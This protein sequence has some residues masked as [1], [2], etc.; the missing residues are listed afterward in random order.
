MVDPVAARGVRG[1][2][3][4]GIDEAGGSVKEERVIIKT[5]RWVT[6][7]RL[8]IRTGLADT[9]GRIQVFFFIRFT[10]GYYF[11]IR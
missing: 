3:V 10:Y 11:N 6:F 4:R 5:G 7:N 8:L 1:M 2:P 9:T